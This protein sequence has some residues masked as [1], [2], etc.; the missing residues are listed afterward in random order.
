MKNIVEF[1]W[2]S[3]IKYRWEI[4]CNS[5]VLAFEGHY[6]KPCVRLWSSI[7]YVIYVVMSMVSRLLEQTCISVKPIRLRREPKAGKS[8]WSVSISL[9]ASQV[10]HPFLH[11]Q[12]SQHN[13][14]V[15][16]PLKL[17]GGKKA[18]VW[19]SPCLCQNKHTFDQYWKTTVFWHVHFHALLGILYFSALK[20][21]GR[22][23]FGAESILFKIYNYKFTNMLF[24]LTFPSDD[25]CFPVPCIYFS[26][27]HL[28]KLLFLFTYLSL[29]ISYNTFELQFMVDGFAFLA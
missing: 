12:H 29:L 26:C 5:Y 11:I 1:F 13:V 15:L 16:I 20:I 24:F 19:V 23:E 14:A 27:V 7:S 9:R 21:L 22:G 6:T 4:E 18:Q 2:N 10:Q 17:G 28:N 3:P 8:Y 25:P